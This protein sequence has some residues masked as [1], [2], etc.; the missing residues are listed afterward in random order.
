MFSSL[1][2]GRSDFWRIGARLLAAVQFVTI[3]ELFTL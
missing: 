2:S 3:P 1:I